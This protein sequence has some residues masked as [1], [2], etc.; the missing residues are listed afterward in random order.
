MRTTAYLKA[1][2]EV[3]GKTITGLR[4]IQIIKHVKERYRCKSKEKK[5]SSRVP[6]LTRDTC[7]TL[8]SYENT[9]IILKNN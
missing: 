3:Y 5:Q 1:I 6:Q 8:E 2:M 9:K 7:T 4:P